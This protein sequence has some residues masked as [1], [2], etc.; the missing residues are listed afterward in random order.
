MWVWCSVSV[1]MDLASMY[2][3]MY[4]YVFLLFSM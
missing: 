3:S 4:N 2:V 1:T